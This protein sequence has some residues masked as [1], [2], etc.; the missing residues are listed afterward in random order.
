MSQFSIIVYAV[1]LFPNLSK[2]LMLLFY[3]VSSSLE[4]ST[5]F[6]RNPLI[7]L[8]LFFI[9]SL[10]CFGVA[11]VIKFSFLTSVCEKTFK[12]SFLSFQ[13]R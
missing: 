4:P 3:K 6:F 12:L 1:S 13:F 2:N 9:P 10:V 11:K 7:S 8:G 5:F